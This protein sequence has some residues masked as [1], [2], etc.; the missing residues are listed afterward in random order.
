MLFLIDLAFSL[1]K[2]YYL[3]RVKKALLHEF[4]LFDLNEVWFTFFFV[5]F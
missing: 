2:W 3:L 1:I 5:R 4:D